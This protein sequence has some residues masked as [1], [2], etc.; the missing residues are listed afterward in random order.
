MRKTNETCQSDIE[1]TTEILRRAEIQYIKDPKQYSFTI[2]VPID[3]ALFLKENIKLMLKITK[4]KHLNKGK[5][6]LFTV[7]KWNSKKLI[8]L[9]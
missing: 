8:V 5:F 2:R 7:A 1:K 4:E 3:F 9:Q 6:W